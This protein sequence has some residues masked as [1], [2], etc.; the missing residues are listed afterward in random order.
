MLVVYSNSLGN[1]FTVLHTKSTAC[2]YF[3]NSN[4]LSSIPVVGALKLDFQVEVDCWK[5]LP[6]G[7]APPS[8]LVIY[9]F[10]TV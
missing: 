7:L 2:F 4:A 3:P 5:R 8:T 10:N 6:F 9:S 1:F